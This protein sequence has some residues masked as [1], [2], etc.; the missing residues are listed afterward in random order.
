MF[1]R[2]IGDLRDSTGNALRM[3]SLAAAAAIACHDGLSL[4]RR[5]RVRSAEIRSG[6][7]MPDGC[8]DFSSWSP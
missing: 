7:G 8:R 3:T 1:Q 5:L 6:G 4:R 2:L